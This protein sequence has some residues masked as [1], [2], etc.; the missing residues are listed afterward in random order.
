MVYGVSGT[1]GIARMYAMTDFMSRAFIFVGGMLPL[2][3]CVLWCR[4]RLLR[5]AAGR[6][7]AVPANPGAA[8]VP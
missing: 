1:E 6:M 8:A 7:E 5:V 4:R 2:I 3:I